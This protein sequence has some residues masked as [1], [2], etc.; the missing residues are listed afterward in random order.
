MKKKSVSTKF[1]VRK[2]AIE[3]TKSVLPISIELTDYESADEMMK[4]SIS[5]YIKGEISEIQLKTLSYAV[6]NFLS[7]K[8][9]LKESSEINMIISDELTKNGMLIYRQIEDISNYVFS[10]I[11]DKTLAAEISR[12]IVKIF[13][14][15]DNSRV[16]IYN[17]IEKLIRKRT[18]FSIDVLRTYDSEMLKIEIFDRIKNL[19]EE[20]IMFIL[21]ELINR[22]PHL[23]NEIT[24]IRY[25]QRDNK[26]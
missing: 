17:D 20:Q 15:I 22:Y 7:V 9:T 19:K 21:N 12:G 5:A 26:Y 3:N 16:D 11:K 6:Q 25:F 13:Q 23:I 24:L 1:P 18:S 14:E 4:Q 8:K 2:N 10:L